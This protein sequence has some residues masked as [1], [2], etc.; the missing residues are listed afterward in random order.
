VRSVEGAIAGDTMMCYLMRREA[1]T[2]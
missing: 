1:G 2:C